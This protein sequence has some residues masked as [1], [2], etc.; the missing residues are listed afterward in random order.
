M[1]TAGNSAALMPA[2]PTLSVVV[3]TYNC[4]PLMAR[5]LTSMA[6]WADLADE[7]VVVD[8]RSTDGTLELIR[9]RLRHPNLRIIER[10]RGLYESWNE[11]IAAST[12]K[13]IYISTIGDLISRQHLLRLIAVGEKHQADVVVSPQRFVDVEGKP[14]AKGVM[15]NPRIYKTFAGQGVVTLEPE[16]TCFYAFK[17]AKPNALLGSLASDLF[18]GEHLRARPFPCDYGTHGDTA[19]T[20]RYSAATRLCLLPLIGSDFCV[21]PKHSVAVGP[22]QET[23]DRMFESESQR[24]EASAVTRVSKAMTDLNLKLRIR[25]L[26]RER[27][28]LKNGEAGKNPQHIAW[29]LKALCYLWFR[30]LLVID[31]CRTSRRLTSKISCDRSGTAVQEAR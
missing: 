5:H 19:W 31:E 3:P 25:R 24:M 11:G 29:M 21:H 28:L 30:L 6:Q 10:D 18:R 4:A 26:M 27:K 9:E 12:G 16:A 13:W 17:S 15:A 7:I 14:L 23:L 20:L 1:T 2:K 8:S 22:L